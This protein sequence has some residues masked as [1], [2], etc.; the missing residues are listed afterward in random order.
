MS[1]LVIVALSST[2]AISAGWG[3]TELP[4]LLIAPAVII[5]CSAAVIA[6]LC[7]QREVRWRDAHPDRVR[8]RFIDDV[9]AETHVVMSDA[10]ADTLIDTGELL[11]EHPHG[12]HLLT[13]IDSALSVRH[14]Q[15]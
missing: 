10:E 8:A 14:F 3:C 2:V 6:L 1:T 7:L 13:L 4:D 12:N 15:N 9:A 5:S 11:V